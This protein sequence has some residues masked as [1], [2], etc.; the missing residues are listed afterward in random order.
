MSGRHQQGFTLIELVIAITVIGIAMTGVM[1]AFSAVA[2]RSAD[3]LVMEQAAAIANAY[4]DE[5]CSKPFVDPDGSSGESARAAFDDLQDYQGLVDVGAHD[6]RGVALA[7]LDDYTIR[8][9][10]VA[11][12]L[13]G[14]PAARVRRIDV[15]V[16][17]GNL[18]VNLSR[19]RT[20][21]P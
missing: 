9:S 1:G 3:T 8:V 10:V 18:V 21:Y 14:I 2:V 19:Y 12:A 15:S 7:G 11:T 6:Q 5:I 20:R 16:S 13:A 4:L 17:Q